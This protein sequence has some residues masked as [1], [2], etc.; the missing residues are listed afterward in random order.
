MPSAYVN[1][2]DLDRRLLLRRLRYIIR[3]VSPYSGFPID[4]DSLLGEDCGIDH[5][6]YL[7]RL[8]EELAEEFELEIDVR[9]EHSVDELLTAI[10]LS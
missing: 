9:S 2:N 3:E 8:K 6:Y 4:E 1:V 10:E 5:D 7:C